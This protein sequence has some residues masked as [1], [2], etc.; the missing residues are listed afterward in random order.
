MGEIRV[1]RPAIEPLRRALDALARADVT[2]ALGGSGLM[3]AL[4]HDAPV[5]DWDLTTDAPLDRVHAALEHESPRP[6]GSSG[7]HAD[8]KLTIEDG[9]VEVIV[10]FAMRHGDTVV[11]LPTI[12]TGEWNGVP[13]G[14][15]E[16]WVVAYALLDRTEKSA[17]LVR[18][19]ESRGA[20]AEAVDRL[21]AQPLPE[22]LRVTLERL[23]IRKD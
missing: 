1:S 19:L 20:R 5:H 15:P 23:P 12:V 2:A 18:H 17:W 3:A 11:R 10:G 22:A 7:I 6:F 21:L 13:L 16:V 14:S 4:G 8:A 9:A